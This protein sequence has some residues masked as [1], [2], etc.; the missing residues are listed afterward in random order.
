VE[1]VYS[2]G[3]WIGPHRLQ[4]VQDLLWWGEAHDDGLYRCCNGYEPLLEE[5]D[6]EYPSYPPMSAE[7]L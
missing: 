1:G 5:D 2:I 6:A 3:Q 7:T 4:R